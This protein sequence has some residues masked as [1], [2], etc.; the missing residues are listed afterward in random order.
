M[1][2]I[3]TYKWDG[4]NFFDVMN[5]NEIGELYGNSDF[6]DVYNVRV[7]KVDSDGTPVELDIKLVNRDTAIILC[8]RETGEELDVCWWREH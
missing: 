3:V 1:N 6:T 2:Y 7:F 8:D 5:R 4:E